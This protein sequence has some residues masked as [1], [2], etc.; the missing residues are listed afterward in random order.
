MNI[1]ACIPT[2][3]GTPMNC[4]NSKD[5]YLTLDKLNAIIRNTTE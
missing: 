2:A 3:D 4:H 1:L 5:L